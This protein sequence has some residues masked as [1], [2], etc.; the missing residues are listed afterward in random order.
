MSE[1]NGAFLK[2][3]LPR[4]ALIAWLDRKPTPASA[5]TDWRDLGGELW[6]AGANVPFAA[7]S[8]ATVARM[9]S[10]SDMILA[11]YGT[12]R[13]ALADL[14]GTELPPYLKYYRHDAQ[15]GAFVA[16]SAMFAEEMAF[17]IAFLSLARAAS[18]GPGHE[19]GGVA[20]VRDYFSQSEDVIAALEMRPGSPSEILTGDR[21]STAAAEFE[22]IANEMFEGFEG[23]PPR[24]VNDLDGLR[25][26]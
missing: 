24:E 8:E 12:V 15:A 17:W 23:G 19:A 20:V 11:A 21:R 14:L 22:S 13:D 7:A 9:L 6:E 2:V 5:W 10:E 16:G 25:A 1:P 18:T 26:A 4:A 3:C